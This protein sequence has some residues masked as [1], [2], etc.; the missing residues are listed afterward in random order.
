MNCV[1][2]IKETCK[3]EGISVAKLERECG[4][5]NGYIQ[6]LRKGILPYDRL[7][8]V[9]DYLGVS[10]AYLLTGEKDDYYLSPEAT[11]IAQEISGNRDLRV[12]FSS[13][14]KTTPEQFKVLQDLV[15]TWLEAEKHDGEDPA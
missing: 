7:S 2:L 15:N 1:D 3:K 10:T 11:E 12:F 13:V 4:F 5:A 6:G 9:A 8:K 14:R